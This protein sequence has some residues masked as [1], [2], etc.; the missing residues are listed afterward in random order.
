MD[1]L[2]GVS[3]TASQPWPYMG[4]TWGIFLKHPCLSPTPRDS[5]VIGLRC[6]LGTEIFFF[7][8]SAGDA[9]VQA[10]LRINGI[11]S[12]TFQDSLRNRNHMHKIRGPTFCCGNNSF[13]HLKQK[14]ESTLNLVSDECAFD[15]ENALRCLAK[16]EK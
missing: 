11:E 5:D 8:S 9:N 4:I 3:T 15:P 7:L 1:S 6:C 10:G 12:T 16:V 2:Q 14:S 13:N